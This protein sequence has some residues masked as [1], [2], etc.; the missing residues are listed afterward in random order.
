MARTLRIVLTVA[1]MASW[2]M[3]LRPIALGGDTTYAYVKGISMEPTYHTA[4]LVVLHKR[5]NYAVGDVVAFQVGDLKII[6]RLVAGNN[7]DGWTTQGDNNP[8]T[9]GV[10]ISNTSIYGSATYVIPQG[11]MFVTFARSPYAWFTVS[12][13]LVLA[14]YRAGNRRGRPARVKDE[15]VIDLRDQSLTSSDSESTRV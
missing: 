9:D 14:A 8:T 15:L 11:G 2:F 5:D 4:D 6:H 1:A 7:V 10:L 13:L 12:G 3:F